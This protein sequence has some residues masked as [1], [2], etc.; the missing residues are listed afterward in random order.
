MKILW[1]QVGSAPPP[2][3]APAGGGSLAVD[4]IFLPSKVFAELADTLRTSESL[5]PAASKT[6]KGW[7]V[8]LL[9]R[10]RTIDVTS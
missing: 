6:F 8:G 7:Q 9:K 1:K 3:N 4:H 10:F 5:L 2:H